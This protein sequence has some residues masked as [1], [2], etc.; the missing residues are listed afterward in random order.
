[1]INVKNL[2]FGYG[3]KTLFQ[4]ANF[5]VSKDQKVGLVGLNGAGKTTLFNLLS[6]KEFPQ[7]GEIEILGK[8]GFVPQ[9]V[10]FD[11]EVDAAPSIREYL[12]QERMDFELKEMLSQLEL[13]DLKLESLPRNLSGGQKTKLSLCRALLSVPEILLL[14]EPTNFMD[15]EGKKW[16]MNFLSHYPKTLI[17][18]SHNLKLM[19]QAI[20]RVLY[21]NEH[22]KKIEEYKGNYSKFLKLKK[23]KEDLFKKNFTAKEKQIKRMEEGVKRLYRHT[24]KKGVRQRVVLERRLERLKEKLPELPPEIKKMR[25]FLPEPLWVGELPIKAKEISKSYGSLKVFKDLNFTI[26]RKERIA[27]LGANG[28]GKSTLIKILNGVLEPDSGEVISDENLSIGYFSQEFEAFDLDKTLLE[29]L[30]EECKLPDG[31]ARAFLGRFNFLGNKVFQKIG[32]LSGG[33]KTRLSIALLTGNNHNLLI[34]DEPTTY[35]DVLSQR[36]ILDALKEYQGTM[37]VV[38]HTEEF[39]SELNPNKAFLM[40]EG[41]MVFW[42]EELLERVSE[43]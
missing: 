1:M 14:D 12:G 8:I 15:K 29:A 4:G 37:I 35:L 39:I 40:P 41:Q 16:V 23:E 42:S 26:V 34:L 18:I 17:V 6:Q 36:I 25:L 27:L 13:A 10:K 21:I 9:E 38:S 24:S 22:T 3:E 2:T 33:E 7:E 31:V 28:T 20:D 43:V 19:D 5:S 30:T 11:P 32:T